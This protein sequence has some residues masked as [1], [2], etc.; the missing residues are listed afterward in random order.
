[1][2]VYYL[3]KIKFMIWVSFLPLYKA[4]ECGDHILLEK[5]K[6]KYEKLANLQ[7]I[8]KDKGNYNFA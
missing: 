5:I 7:E 2:V 4:N 6:D 3:S 8:H 1:M